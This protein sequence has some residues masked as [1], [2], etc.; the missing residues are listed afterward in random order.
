M[1]QGTQVGVCVCVH[2]SVC[3]HVHTGVLIYNVRG[4]IQGCVQ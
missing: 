4:V 1:W 2:V 3:A